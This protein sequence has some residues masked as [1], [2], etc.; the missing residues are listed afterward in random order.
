MKVFTKV[1]QTAMVFWGI[2][3]LYSFDSEDII[4]IK[5]L[6]EVVEK[7]DRYLL[8]SVETFDG[9]TPW[10][11]YRSTSFLESTRFISKIPVSDAF[12]LESSLYYSEE[13]TKQKSLQ[14]FSNIEIPGRDKIFVKPKFSKPIPAGTPVRAFFWV[15]SNNYDI[16]LK[17]IFSQKKS[18]D[19]SVNFGTL[20]FNGWRRMDEK[21][22]IYN[23]QDRLNLAKFSKFELKG[24]LLESSASQTKGS[25]F[26]FVDQMGVLVEKSEIYPGSEIPDGWELY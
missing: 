9:E 10:A 3:S 25:F 13:N 23:P 6:K 7:G 11:V 18:Q 1:F 20:K 16:N 4:K 15:Y 26:I 19:I 17:L 12:Q 22:T 24:I 5:S 8:H 14:I 21:I 2:V